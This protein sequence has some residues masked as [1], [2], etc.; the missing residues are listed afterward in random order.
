MHNIF[1]HASTHTH[2]LTL[3][4]HREKG[5][6]REVVRDQEEGGRKG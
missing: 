5:V 6:G 3:F 1:M 4:R 2:T